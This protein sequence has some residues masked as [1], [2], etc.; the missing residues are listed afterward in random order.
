MVVLCFF[1]WED[2]QFFK[3]V[4]VKMECELTCESDAGSEHAF[5]VFVGIF[6]FNDQL[7]ETT[8]NKHGCWRLIDLSLTA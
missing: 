6:F 1:I 3:M 5:G 4:W 7:A 2:A 8:S